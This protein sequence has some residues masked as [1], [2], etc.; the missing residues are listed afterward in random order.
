MI[1]SILKKVYFFLKGIPS[2]SNSGK[3]WDERYKKGGNSGAG[4][5]NNLAEFKGKIINEF[6]EENNIETVIEFGCGDGNQLKYFDFKSYFGFD[7]SNTA[8]SICKELYKADSSKQFKLLESFDGEKAQLTL[9]LDVIFHLVEEEVYSD[10]MKKLFS[11]SL[12][13]VIIY[14]SNHNELENNRIAEHVKHRKFS[15]WVE[16]NAV[17][18]ELIKFIPNEYPYD[19]NDIRTSFSDFYIFQKRK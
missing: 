17:D 16:K 12:K 13:Y 11:S 15:E 7:V 14:S 18:F 10:Y 3:Y 6:V 9:S 4:S 2:F 5:Y 8:I 19:E 1:K